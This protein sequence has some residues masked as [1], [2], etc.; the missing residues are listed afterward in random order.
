MT[1]KLF[2]SSEKILFPSNQ[3]IAVLKSDPIGPFSAYRSSSPRILLFIKYNPVT[4][5][6]ASV[7]G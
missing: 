4:A 7:T 6:I 1:G 5:A 3:S 2:P